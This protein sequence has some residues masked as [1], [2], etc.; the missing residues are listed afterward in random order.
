ME[1]VKLDTVILEAK[2]NKQSDALEKL[3]NGMASLISKPK[4]HSSESL[5]IDNPICTESTQSGEDIPTVIE[6]GDKEIVHNLVLSLNESDDAAIINSDECASSPNCINS[7]DAV[8]FFISQPQINTDFPVN[9]PPV[10]DLTATQP[11]YTSVNESRS[12]NRR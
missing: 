2:F 9:E 4:A 5:I 6:I 10:I 12:M 1:G 11:Y 8:D 3:Q 7:Y